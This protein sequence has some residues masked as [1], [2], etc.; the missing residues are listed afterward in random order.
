MVLEGNSLTA[1]ETLYNSFYQH[2]LVEYLLVVGRLENTDQLP[3][4]DTYVRLFQN[5]F[6][7]INSPV[8][9]MTHSHQKTDGVRILDG[10]Q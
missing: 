8:F 5:S 7:R 9:E 4:R 3:K 2:I 10:K 6:E 1:A